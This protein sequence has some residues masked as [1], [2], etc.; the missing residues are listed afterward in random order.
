MTQPIYGVPP[1][2]YVHTNVMV[3]QGAT[4]WTRP[5]ALMQPVWDAGIDGRGC[6]GISLDTGW[7][8][9]PSLPEPLDGKN[10]TGGGS[11][12]I[13]DRHSH[14]VHTIGSMAGRNGIGGAPGAGIKVGKVLGDNGSG[15][16]T[17]AGLDWAAD[18]EGDVVNCSWG[19]GQS[20]DSGTER[21]MKRI[22]ES[23][24]WLLFSGGNSGFNGSN[25][26]IAPA[27]SPTNVAVSSTN[28]DGSLSGFSSGGP[29]I[30]LAAGGGGI[31]SCGL[32][33][34]LVL[35]SG[36]S[37]ASPTAA[38]DLL[39]L[40]QA[41]KQLGMDVYMGMR[42]LVAFLRSEEFLKDAGPVGRDPRFGDGVVIVS[43][44]IITWIL[45]KTTGGS[46]T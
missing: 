8:A 20:V 44:N 24:K 36:T 42:E 34:D 28:Q 38:G 30:D 12:N 46:G 18:Q 7:K 41:M 45:A 43:K 25:T 16:N 29:A 17:I 26:V 33:N 15:S 14:G 32:N 21:A 9:H 19:G 40:R 5:P 4:P 10:F 39:L 31:I 3:M 11:S 35:M 13:T 23:G 1:D 27:I 22:V 2:T 37:M 6:I